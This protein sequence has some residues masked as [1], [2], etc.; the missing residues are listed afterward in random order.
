N[1]IAV[2]V[3]LGELRLEGKEERQ[4]LVFGREVDEQGAVLPDAIVPLVGR[5]TSLVQMDVMDAVA[6]L[7]VEVVVRLA[8][9]GPPLAAEGIDVG[10]PVDRSFYV[11]IEDLVQVVVRPRCIE[12]QGLHLLR[13]EEAAADEVEGHSARL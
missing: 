4:P 10:S 11:E 5:R 13:I 9:L 8:G 6:G 7:E 12:G 1:G 3:G 2:S